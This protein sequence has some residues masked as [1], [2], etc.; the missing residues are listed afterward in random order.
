MQDI[1]E[2]EKIPFP[3]V[4]ADLP[5][6]GDAELL[7]V[8]LESWQEVTAADPELAAFAGRLAEIDEGPQILAS[9][10]G[11]SPFLSSCLLAEPHLLRYLVEDGTE[12]TLQWIYNALHADCELEAERETVMA[13]LR[14]AKRRIALLTALSDMGKVWELMKITGVLSTFA[15]TAVEICCRHLLKAA[16]DKGELTLPH[17][18]DPTKDSGL[19]IIGMGKLGAGELNYSSDIDLVILF[20]AAKTSYTGRRSVQD[21]FVRI[22]R[23]LVTMM[24][25]RT[26]DGYV[27]RT[28]LRLRPDPGATPIALSIG[29][30]HVYYESQGQNW[31]RAAMI[32]ARA[33]AGDLDAGAE[34]VSFL[35][36]FIWRKSMDFAAIEDIQA[37]KSQI[38][39]HKGFSK[40]SLE[41]HNIK[42]GRGGI[43]EIEFFC[44]TQQLIEGGRNPF[45]RE[46]TTLGTLSQLAAAGKISPAVRGELQDAYIYLREL[47]HRLQMIH[48]EQTQLLP[49][50]AE[51]FRKLGVFFG[52]DEVQEFRASLR[53]TLETVQ[54][55]YDALF[56]FEETTDRKA[57]RLVF[58]GAE[59]DPE[60]LKSLAELGF[61]ETSAISQKVREWHHGR[62]RATRTVRAQQILTELIPQLLEALGDTSNPD[63]AFTRFDVFL[64]K[65]PAGIQLFTMFKAHPSLLKLLAKIM[66][67]APELAETLARNTMLLDGVLDTE[68]MAPLLPKTFLE[69]DLEMILATARDFQDVLD[70]TRRWAND[71]KFRLGVQ[72]LDNVDHGTGLGATVAA[73]PAFSDVTEVILEAILF[74]TR[75]EFARTHGVVPGGE[76]AVIG[77]GKLGSRQMTP[78]SDADLIFLFETPEED[79]VTDGQKPISAGL[80]YTRFCQRYINALSVHTGEGQLYE[81][82]MR[83]RPHGKSGPIALKLASARKYYEEEAWTWEHL[84]LT[85]ARVVAGDPAL[86]GRAEKMLREIALTRR[87]P[88][89][90]RTETLN[91]RRRVLKQ[92]GTDNP[93]T[94]K[95]ARG[96]LMDL[97][98]LCQYL[99]L[100]HGPD[101]PDILRP[102]SMDSLKVMKAEGILPAETADRL[103]DIL[104][105]YLNISGLKQLCL[106]DRKIDE[107]IP[108]ALKKALAE[109]GEVDT[110]DA[111][112][113]KLKA[114]QS[115][116]DRLLNDYLGKGATAE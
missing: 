15:D 26:R 111:L 101:H 33:I 116:V 12:R 44:Q 99:R 3:D 107:T 42:I 21:C 92:H 4:M 104:K 66:G 34:F 27:F 113:K 86:C 67:M 78:A 9:I 100:K 50:D 106:G 72:I 80:Y 8:G 114:A 96:G 13:A 35:T 71:R 25:E 76:F 88:E 2:I 65:L 79:M 83:L 94:V 82:D 62:Y 39:T 103:V 61:E 75:E 57:G 41:G 6:P 36:P 46:V 87:D 73:G 93:L 14:I 17:P 89:K 110:F 77:M 16:S 115:D 98:F 54:R 81:V 63:A 105:L 68:F 58:T 40:I 56:A 23:N 112:A 10:F 19:I 5:A 97:E 52:Y 28:D 53:A 11:N 22:A 84:A 1:A 47:E 109:A 18:D 29:A 31:E 69:A 30:A 51:D 37:I 74:K 91:M 85:R 70:Y 43:R 20:D 45:L 55:H 59:D 95:H 24:Q 60:T 108:L 48:D 32:K 102:N 7:V 90:I 64:Q 49:D 38:H